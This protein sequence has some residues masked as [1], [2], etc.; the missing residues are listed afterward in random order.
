MQAVRSILLATDFSEDAGHA[1]ARAALLATELPA[2]LRML[3]VLSAPALSAL[4]SLFSAGGDAEARLLQD[5]RQTLDALASLLA[6]TSGLAIDCEVRVGKV[7]DEILA[8][9]AR[10]DLLVLG[11]RGS[12]PLRDR[13][14]GTT[15]ERLI[16]RLRGPAL[17]SR[18]PAR[19]SYRNVLVA[20]DFSPDAT[21][22]LQGARAV[23]PSAEITV[24]HA[25]DMP[26]ESRL[27]SAGVPEAEIQLYRAQARQSAMQEIERMARTA[28]L[29]PLAV[30]RIVQA[31][32]PSSVVLE[33]AERIGADLIVI[34]KHGQSVVEELMLGSVTRHVLADAK[35]DVLVARHHAGMTP[36]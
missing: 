9:A 15:A 23:A 7:P 25:F 19:E 27:W 5:A 12:S 10:C 2:S 4:R 8:A 3:H 20:T 13:I 34:G 30:A 29:D 11:A 17:V 21:A 36:G 26:F 33:H 1:A 22:A 31:G 14:L 16:A 6:G 32:H 28:G 35:C 18:Q 24:V